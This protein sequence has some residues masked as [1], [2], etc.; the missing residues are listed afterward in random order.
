[1]AAY[2]TLAELKGALA[3]LTIGASSVPNQT[4]VQTLID[5]TSSEI[6]TVLGGRGITPPV[7]TPAHFVRRLAL[8]NVYGAAAAT[9]KAFF[10]EARGAGENPAYAFWEARY[11]EGLKALRTG[12]DIPTD[13]GGGDESLLPSSYFT[14]NPD[15]EETLGDLAGASMFTVA[16]EF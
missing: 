10:P 9:L 14:R 8:L 2:A 7:T 13:V 16:K 12:D 5:D 1:M 6:D 15:Q 3:Y 11:R 4:Q